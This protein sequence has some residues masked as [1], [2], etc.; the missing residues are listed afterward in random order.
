M[1]ESEL[2]LEAI[3]EVTGPATM[4][5]KGTIEEIARQADQRRRE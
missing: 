2:D 4:R 3:D 1:L 5:T